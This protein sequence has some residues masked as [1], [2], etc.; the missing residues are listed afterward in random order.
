MLGGG[1]HDQ[2][3]AARAVIPLAPDSAKPALAVRPQD[4]EAAV[5]LR[6]ETR[7]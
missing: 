2:R 6:A 1:H 3:G 4:L 5:S 7:G